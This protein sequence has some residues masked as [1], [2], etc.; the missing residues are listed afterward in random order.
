MNKTVKVNLL[1]ASEEH[2]VERL[3]QSM[4]FN[5]ENNIKGIHGDGNAGSSEIRT[6]GQRQ[7]H[8]KSG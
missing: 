7:E 6:Q 8:R 3:F 4:E 5:G 1:S 2:M